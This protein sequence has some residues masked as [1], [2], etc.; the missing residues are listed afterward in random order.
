[1]FR[2]AAAERLADISLFPILASLGLVA[3]ITGVLSFLHGVFPIEHVT[4]VFLVPV[5][6]CAAR[7]GY[8]PAL[9]A[10]F[11]GVAAAD[12]FFYPPL[13]S[14][15]VADPRDVIDLIAFTGVAVV[16]SEFA[17]RL[18]RAAEAARRREKEV[19]DLYAFSRRLAAC[20][21]A[22]E[23]HAAIQDYL[24]NNLGSRAMLIETAAERCDDPSL[25]RLDLPDAVRR[26]ALDMIAARD[27]DSRM[28]T[29]ARTGHV[30]LIRAVSR[31]SFDF[32]VI[33]VELGGAAG[34]IVDAVERRIDDV[35]ADAATTLGR[36]DVARLIDE[37][38]LRAQ[39][40][41][42]REALL[43]SVSHELRTPLASILGATTVLVD[44]PPIRRDPRLSALLE[45]LHGEAGR[46]ND[47]IQNLLDA[48]RITND[49]IRPQAQWVDPAD[50]VNAAI[51]RRRPRLAGRR[52]D[53]QIAGDLPLIKVEARLIEQAFG[54]IL[55]NAA[56]YSPSGSLLAI[57]V[58]ADG[59]RVVLSVRD[60]GIGLT[61]DEQR[62]LWDR[63]FR[64]ARHP[65]V[66]GAGLGLWI[67][68]AFVV[69]NGGTIDAASAGPRCGTTISV[70]LPGKPL[71][72]CEMKE[73]CDA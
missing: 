58:A 13:Y 71:A 66:G 59:D 11:A 19:R 70:T 55:E 38:R 72:A 46:L 15:D 34:K 4:L 45:V 28:A 12:F 57:R 20:T 21:E 42:L 65:D 17:V 32:G 73:A 22:A 14:F 23:I 51:E 56:K 10:T 36:L 69:A 64:G 5:L 50:I 37:A 27:L 8:V 49:N 68:R 6:I 43:G 7:W 33:A 9:T 48:T 26:T 24:S 67:A 52:I 3:A 39:T 53:T 44:A 60:E 16:T 54:Q 41:L 35:L 25:E 40:E 2:G 61:R 62:R 47:D 29:D 18:R 31:E 30:W 1:M 63:S